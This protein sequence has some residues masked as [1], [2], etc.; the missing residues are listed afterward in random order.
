[1]FNVKRIDDIR[2]KIQDSTIMA[3][4]EKSDWLN[5]LELM[6]D[7]QL[8]ELEDILSATSAMTDSQS[9]SQTLSASQATQSVQS[10]LQPTQPQS[11]AQQSSSAT[12][13]NLPPLKHLANIPADL[14]MTHSVPPPVARTVSAQSKPVQPPASSVPPKPVN[15]QVAP[16]AHSTKLVQPTKPVQPTRPAQPIQTP[17]S[18]E[19]AKP[20]EELVLQSVSE[21]QNF[22]VETLRGYDLQSIINA[23]LAAIQQNGYF[24][25]LQILETSPLY[26]AYIESGKAMLNKTE[27]PLSRD[28]FEFITDLLR[29]MRFNH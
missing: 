29:H 1:M 11:S 23:V 4:H 20:R 5:L 17:K 24:R 26:Q 13:R 18:A 8:G 6:N 28:E 25:V 27:S 22:T 16:P 14:N 9:T 12:A 2:H 15:H 19:P 7:K 10:S 21:I 3:D